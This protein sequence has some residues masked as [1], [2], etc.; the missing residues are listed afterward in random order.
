MTSLRM[1]NQKKEKMKELWNLINWLRI[2]NKEGCRERLQI[3]SSWH[4]FS[5]T[6]KQWKTGIGKRMIY[7]N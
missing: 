6:M 4:T 5:G 1:M 2:L 3:A 7:F